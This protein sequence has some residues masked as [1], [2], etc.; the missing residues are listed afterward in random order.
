M[1]SQPFFSVILP[2][3]NKGRHIKRALDS[4]FR[5]SC[6]DFE[7]IV[8]DDSSTDEGLKVVIGLQDSRIRIF[9][10]NTPG[11][12]G[13]AARNLAAENAIGEWIVFLDA[14]DEWYPEHLQKIKLAANEYPNLCTIGAGWV[15]VRSNRESANKY[16]VN[17]KGYGNRCIGLN[18]YLSEAIRD[19]RPFHTSAVAMNREFFLKIG[20]FPEGRAKK[21]G[22]LYLW[23]KAV[24][25]GNSYWS[26]HL[27]ARYYHTSDNKV[28]HTATFST[29]LIRS[30][31]EELTEFV[32][33]DELKLLKIYANKM[34]RKAYIE[35]LS[36][37]AELTDSLLDIGFY[38]GSFDY[39]ERLLLM[40]LPSFVFRSKARIRSLL[41]RIK[42]GKR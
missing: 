16:F 21:G 9:S 10:R 7:I 36:K 18:G 25:Y 42:N 6:M 33:E 31:V 4:V 12:G 3:Y 41:S 26:A 15:S 27:G 11:P 32:S 19:R 34:M 14:D 37:G 35:K 40:L 30:M 13:Y 17:K 24:A 39:F 5:Q 20:G 28:I 2:L 8:V 22:D 38:V 23:V 1:Q 29:V